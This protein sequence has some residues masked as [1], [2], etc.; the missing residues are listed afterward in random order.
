MRGLLQFL[1]QEEQLAGVE[2]NA[3]GVGS[4]SGYQFLQ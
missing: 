1:C 3:L 2:Y 4:R